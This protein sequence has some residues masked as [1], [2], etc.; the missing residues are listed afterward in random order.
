MPRIA[1]ADK[2]DHDALPEFLRPRHRAVLATVRVD[3]S[4]QNAL[5]GPE[6]ES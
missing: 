5:A 1:T 3:G 6:V 2:V 4:P